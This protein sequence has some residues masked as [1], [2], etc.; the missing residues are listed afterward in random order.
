MRERPASRPTS[1]LNAAHGS[2]A[3]ERRLTKRPTPTLMSSLTSNTLEK[4]Q[5]L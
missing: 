1:T 4:L 5:N 3:R 2:Y